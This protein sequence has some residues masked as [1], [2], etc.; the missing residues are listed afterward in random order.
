VADILEEA[1]FQVLEA[2]HADAALV[3]LKEQYASVTLL[4]SDVHMPGSMNGFGLAHVTATHRPH[5]AIVIASGRAR[6]SPG[7]LPDGAR[8]VAKPFS[9]EVVRDH[10]RQVLPADCQPDLLRA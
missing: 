8:F 3:L 6:P 5:I 1:G 4:F 9:A 2:E 7:E 10:L